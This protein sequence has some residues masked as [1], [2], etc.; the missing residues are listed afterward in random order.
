MQFLVS[1]G[2]GYVEDGREI[3]EDDDGDDLFLSK[4]NK[5]KKQKGGSGRL[6]DT[7]QANRGSTSIRNMIKNMPVKKKKTEVC[8][9]FYRLG[10]N[11]ETI[12]YKPCQL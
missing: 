2:S 1:D 3:F 12:A 6:S 8:A 10:S 9:V 5:A 11:K 4:K 7:S